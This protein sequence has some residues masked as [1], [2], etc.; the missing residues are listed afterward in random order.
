MEAPRA[1]VLE[2]DLRATPTLAERSAATIFLLL[3]SSLSLQSS[4][5]AL[6]LRL[7][8]ID[9]LHGWVKSSD[10]TLTPTT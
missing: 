2:V 7:C 1:P 8:T 5:S 9:S 10:N 6:L 3:H 4:T